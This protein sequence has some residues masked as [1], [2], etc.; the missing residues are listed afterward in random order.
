MAKGK[1]IG[2]YFERIIEQ[3]NTVYKNKG[4]ALI[5]KIP[6]PIIIT[7]KNKNRI[8][9]FLESKSTVD[10]VGIYKGKTIC[11]DAKAIQKD[12]RFPLQNVQ[13]HQVK[14]ME[15]VKK[16]GGIAFIVINFIEEDKKFVLFIDE[17]SKKYKTWQK[18]KGKRGYASISIEEL[19]EIGIE[20]KSGRGCIVDYLKA[21]E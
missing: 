19:E 5:G 3:A 10:Y 7:R 1:H 2:D 17:L 6:T 16:H 8:T 14:Y 9:G 15:E 21:V 4:I 18:N 20:V 11:F 12:K 13:A